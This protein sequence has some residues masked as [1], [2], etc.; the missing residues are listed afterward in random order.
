MN[1][2]EIIPQHKSDFEKV[3]II[4]ML[5]LKDIKPILPDLLEW[6]QDAN[7]PIAKPIED[8]VLHFKRSWCPM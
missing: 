6:L 1:P 8:I 7:W 5:D 3:E 2:S 4:K